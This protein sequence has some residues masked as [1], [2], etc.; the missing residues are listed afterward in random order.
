[1]GQRTKTRNSE[2][3]F[4]GAP[5]ELGG[6]WGRTLDV[7]AGG[8]GVELGAPMQPNR[9]VHGQIVLGGKNYDFAGE[10]VWVRGGSK[11][12]RAGIRFHRVDG[13]LISAANAAYQ[14]RAPAFGAGVA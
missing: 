14:A 3:L 4:I 7:S 5:V 13:Q 2:R 8:C 6:K 12:S 1:M 9:M 11:Y 10:L